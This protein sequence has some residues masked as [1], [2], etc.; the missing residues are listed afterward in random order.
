MN[1]GTYRELFH[2]AAFPVFAVSQKG[3]LIYKNLACSKY[4]SQIYNS[5]SIKTKIYPKFPEESGVVRVLD[6][7]S[8]SIALA[9]KDEDHWLFL[10]FSRF[11]YTDGISVANKLLQN[12]GNDLI[13]FLST[14]K[15]QGTL[16]EYCDFNSSFSDESLVA[17]VQNEFGI[18]NT[19][20][21]SLFDVMSPVFNKLDE[22]FKPLNYHL[23]TTIE[24]SFPQYLTVRISV[25]DLLFLFGKLLYFVMKYSATKHVEIA[26]FSELAYSNQVLR[27]MT[28]VDSKE[29]PMPQGNNVLLLEKLMP[30][31]AAEIELLNR[32]GLL[33]SEDLS[34][35]VDSLGM[36]SISYKLAYQEPGSSI[37]QSVDD[38]EFMLANNIEMMIQSVW[39]KLKDK[40]ASC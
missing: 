12:F 26:L 16:S 23:T 33:K 30:E 19:R 15:Q 31:C 5:R 21:V 18:W 1:V 3:I 7:A 8:Y 32:A 2:Y 14:F 17:L 24:Q 36:M 25:G 9:L 38:L 29:F 22:F 39:E 27:L 35:Y 10:C 6:W 11:Q 20:S 34:F 28:K 40:D 13:E 4:L 37:L